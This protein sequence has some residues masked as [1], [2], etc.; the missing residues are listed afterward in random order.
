MLVIGFQTAC[1]LPC[2]LQEE[3]TNGVLSPTALMATGLSAQPPGSPHAA[4]EG[5]RW[6]ELPHVTDKETKAPRL[7]SLPRSLQ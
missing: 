4:Q 7:G 5:P 2:E 1:A 3:S 6:Q